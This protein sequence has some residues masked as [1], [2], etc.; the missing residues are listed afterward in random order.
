MDLIKLIA[1]LRTYRSQV[2]EVIA[3]IEELALR[4]SAPRRAARRA[5]R[6]AAPKAAPRPVLVKTRPV[7]RRR[8]VARKNKSR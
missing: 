2:E 8:R 1:E 5:A 7:R 6:K 3:A 4:R